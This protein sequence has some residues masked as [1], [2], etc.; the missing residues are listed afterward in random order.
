[1]NQQDEAAVGRKTMRT[2]GTIALVSLLAL[3]VCATTA[4]A[5]PLSMT[6]TEARAN[7]GEQLDDD[8][9]FEAP[10]TAPFEAQIDPEDG[11]ITAGVLDVPAFVTEITE[12]I[13]ADVTVDFEIGIITGSFDQATNVLILEGQAGGTLTDGEKNCIVSTTPEILTLSTAGN[14]GGVSPRSG[15]SF[16]HG[17]TG[18]GAIAGQWS[19][20]TADPVDT[21][22]GGDTNFCE[23]VN[24]RIGGPGGIWLEHE[25]VP[26]PPP[27]GG[28]TPTPPPTSPGPPQDGASPIRVCVVPKLA[29]KRLPRARRAL[30]RANCKLGKVR[31]RWQLRRKLRRY[32]K[33]R[34]RLVV[35][36]SRPRAGVRRARSGK[37]HVILGLKRCKRNSRC[38]RV[39]RKRQAGKRAAKRSTTG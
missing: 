26:S 33:L 20:M 24:D 34:R 21:E 5:E 13:E 7:V 8:A 23:N 4:S 22:P 36:A 16:T 27:P 19:G 28:D 35:K 25:G 17:L 6:F 30:R 39:K 9:L 18:S 11:E 10:D 1:V 37:V 15:A 31:V 29:G 38:A 2:T 12:P 32:P 14:S 3:G